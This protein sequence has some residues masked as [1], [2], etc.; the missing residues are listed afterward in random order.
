MLL[1]ALTGVALFLLLQRAGWRDQSQR[2][3]AIPRPAPRPPIQ[4]AAKHIRL[5]KT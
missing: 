1:L 3:S 2:A 5:S 4:G